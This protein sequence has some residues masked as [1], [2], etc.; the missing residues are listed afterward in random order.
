MDKRWTEHK[1]ARKAWGCEAQTHRRGPW[2]ARGR[3]GRVAASQTG[4]GR[5]PAAACARWA[6]RR[7]STRRPAMRASCASNAGARR[8]ADVIRREQPGRLAARLHDMRRHADGAFQTSHCLTL[9]G[10]FPR[11]PPPAHGDWAGVDVSH[12]ADYLTLVRRVARRFRSPASSPPRACACP[13]H[14]TPR[15]R[16]PHRSPLPALSCTPRQCLDRLAR[17]R[18]PAGCQKYGPAPARPPANATPTP[19]TSLL[20]LR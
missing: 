15:L 1:L 13:L 4:V 17:R 16:P 20:H 5:R 10:P 12:R 18:C 9:P 11:R 19:Q 2:C 6:T 14:Q 7:G 8:D 3:A